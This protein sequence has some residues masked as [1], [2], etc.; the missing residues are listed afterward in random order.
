[1]RFI[2]F[3]LLF[4]CATVVAEETTLYFEQALYEHLQD[5]HLSAITLSEVLTEKT[6]QN[7]I[8]QQ[9]LL[10]NSYFKYRLPQVSLD[11]LNQGLKL[12]GNQSDQDVLIFHI[13]KNHYDNQQLQLALDSFKKIVNP[14]NPIFRQQLNYLMADIY[15]RKNDLN[16]AQIETTRL[17]GNVDYFPYIAHNLAIAYLN[18]KELQKAL[19]WVKTLNDDRYAKHHELKDSLILATGIVYLREKQYPKAIDLLLKIQKQSAYSAKGL[20]AL[21]QALVSNN[22]P[23]EGTRFYNY[24]SNYPKQN[25]YYQESLIALAE[26]NDNESAKQLFEHAISQYSDLIVQINALAHDDLDDAL[27]ACLV[28]K[29]DDLFCENTH[30][31]IAELEQT[32]SFNERLI[33]NKQLLDI[34]HTLAEW[35]KKIPVYQFILKQRK[36]DFE[37]KLPDIKKK[38]NPTQLSALKQQFS[39]LK[40]QIDE[41]K[42]SFSPYAFI[43]EDESDHL[44]DIRYVEVTIKRINQ[45]SI[46]SLKDRAQFTKGVLMWDLAQKRPTRLRQV[47][48]NLNELES[49]LNSAQIGM[50]KL[51]NFNDFGDIRLT[52]LSEDLSLAEQSISQLKERVNDL[53]KQNKQQLST[54]TRQYLLQ[55]RGILIR[56]DSRSKY[57]LT[58][59]QDVQK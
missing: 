26:L 20:L 30:L 33:Q 32:P 15:I 24:L 51:K 46:Q 6:N 41:H 55:R 40:S 13:A 39:D 56:L 47:T 19:V 1:M 35:S 57:L 18:N 44:E 42:A 14:A 16:N 2:P 37:N 27:S 21:G 50:D 7:D 49:L 11:L 4:F 58:Q 8:K 25:L 38:F 53:I 29:G 28:N 45:E 3:F 10:S 48:K 17:Q 52:Q 23:Q 36:D 22:K 5:N 12:K 54:I 31:W 59:L 34:Q 9:V 43:N